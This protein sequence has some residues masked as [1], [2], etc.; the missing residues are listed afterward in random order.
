MKLALIALGT[1]GTG[2]CAWQCETVRAW[3]ECLCE[4]A[5]IALGLA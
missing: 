2:I 1:A 4:A 3:L 5:C